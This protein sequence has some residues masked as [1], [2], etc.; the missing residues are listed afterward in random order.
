MARKSKNASADEPKSA[1]HPTVEE[2]FAILKALDMVDE[3]DGK[4]EEV[5]SN[6]LPL[7]PIRDQVYFPHMI[8]PLLVGREKSV[9]ALEEAAAQ[10]RHIF[11]VSQSNLHAEDP[12]PD[13]IYSVG[14]AA[15][16]MQIL[17]V[18]DGTVRVMLEGLERC[19]IVKYLQTE[20]FYRVQ[21][22]TLKTLENKDLS[23]EALMRSV[24]SQF[25]QVVSIS[26]NIQPEALINVVNTDEPGRL[27]DVIT[28]YLRQMRVEA[29]QEVLETLDVRE[30]L[31]K[32][33]LVLKKEA[34]I[35]E[36]QKNIRTRVEKE[37]G[38][39]QREFILREQMKAIQQELGEREEGG[40]MEGYRAKIEA[41]GMPPESAERANKEVDRLERMPFAAP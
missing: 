23:T 15:E 37:M 21:V 12:D 30:R 26:K 11:I 19:R 20:P 35:L 14:I 13:D 16:I 24:T 32:L 29:Q 31:E 40:E 2:A 18:P 41:A 25:E 22:E 1:K 6:V 34:E 27:A 39:T 4:V 17:R 38:D 36:I 7:L 3:E 5:Y 33:S 10:Q 8:F 28:P 9:R